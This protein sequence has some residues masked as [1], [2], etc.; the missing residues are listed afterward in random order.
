MIRDA[1]DAKLKREYR[2]TRISPCW[3]KSSA[4]WLVVRLAPSDPSRF[5]RKRELKAESRADAAQGWIEERLLR[6]SDVMAAFDFASKPGPFYSSLERSFRH[7]LM[8][9][10]PS[11]EAQNLVERASALMRE[12]VQFDEWEFTGRSW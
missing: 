7:F 8:N 11:T 3:S 10:A 6:R 4:K 12:L 2:K 1:E 5:R 9:A